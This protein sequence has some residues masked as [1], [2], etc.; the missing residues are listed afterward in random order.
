MPSSSARER[1]HVNAARSRFLHHLAQL[2]GQRDLALALHER[3]FNLKHVAAD[4][5]PRQVR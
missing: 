1:T 2:A 3:R 5:R 4:L